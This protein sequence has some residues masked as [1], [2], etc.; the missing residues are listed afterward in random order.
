M[1]D[2][3]HN[4][5]I[6]SYRE[7]LLTHETTELLPAPNPS[8]ALAV[9]DHDAFGGN[10]DGV[11]TA[12]DSIWGDLYMWFDSNGDHR[13]NRNEL[14][15]LDALDLTEIETIPRYVPHEATLLMHMRGRSQEARQ[16]AVVR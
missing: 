9:Y 12:A 11:I 13:P 16:V 10:D 3:N 2:L 1:A 7:L 6:D 4:G 5:W 15:H 8:V 14:Q